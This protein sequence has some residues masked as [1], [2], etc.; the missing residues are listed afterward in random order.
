[1]AGVIFS[2][3]GWQTSVGI[4]IEINGRK[5][6]SGGETRRDKVP[7]SKMGT[8]QFGR[9]KP[10]LLNGPSRG[11]TARLKADAIYCKCN[12]R[13]QVRPYKIRDLKM[14][15]RARTIKMARPIYNFARG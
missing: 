9:L 12:R 3:P 11:L 13:E 2:W 15:G 14:C 5:E 1:M 10:E 4:I 6:W 8:L 7:V